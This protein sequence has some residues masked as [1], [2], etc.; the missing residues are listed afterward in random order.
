VN[1]PVGGQAVPGTAL[2]D[3]QEP[4]GQAGETT[5]HV[6]SANWRRRLGELTLLTVLA[7]G[8]IFIHQ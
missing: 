8:A 6:V 1:P 3:L 2:S 4:G 7:V 5:L